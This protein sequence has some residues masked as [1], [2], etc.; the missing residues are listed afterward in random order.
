MKNLIYLLC[1]A[2]FINANGMLNAQEVGAV[3]KEVPSDYIGRNPIYD[4]SENRLNNTDTIPDFETQS[5][6]LKITGTIF[7]NDGVTPAKDVIL[8]IYQ[9]D[10]NGDYEMK[11]SNQKRY[12]HNRGWIKTDADGKY[13]FYTFVPGKYYGKGE[14]KTIHPVIKEPGKPEY[15]MYSFLFDDDPS[16]TKSCRKKLEKKGIDNI[17]KLDKKE[18][19]FVATRD[20]V[21]GQKDG[22]L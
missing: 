22:G 4:Y 14:F 16:L 7:L 12:V 15:K 13:T 1:F 19:M 3:L 9:S 20:I 17:L 6:K 18:G 10:D 21:L 5:A 2:S 8:F 11:I